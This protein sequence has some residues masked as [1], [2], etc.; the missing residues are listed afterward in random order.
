MPRPEPRTALHREQRHIVHLEPPRK[1][2][3]FVL[4]KGTARRA[5]VERRA[6]CL[7]GYRLCMVGP[8]LRDRLAYQ[9]PREERNHMPLT[10]AQLRFVIKH[11]V[12]VGNMLYMCRGRGVNAASYPISEHSHTLRSDGHDRSFRMRNCCC[13]LAPAG[14]HIAP[15][16][17]LRTPRAGRIGCTCPG[18]S[19]ECRIATGNRNKRDIR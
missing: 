10:H 11:G 1:G 5:H 18:T 2:I 15:R 19:N 12:E 14:Q 4:E 13:L 6:S 7:R 9:R 17:M 8:Q 3:R 16:R